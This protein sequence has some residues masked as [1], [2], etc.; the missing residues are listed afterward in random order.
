LQPTLEIASI[1]G[2]RKTWI[3]DSCHIDT[4]ATSRPS[5]TQGCRRLLGLFKN[6]EDSC[7]L[8]KKKQGDFGFFRVVS[9]GEVRCTAQGLNGFLSKKRFFVKGANPRVN[10]SP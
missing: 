6:K 4:N 10:S 8:K 1:W 3:A 9:T 7:F 2:R 5:R